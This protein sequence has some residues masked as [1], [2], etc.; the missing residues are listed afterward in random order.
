MAASFATYFVH[1][2]LLVP[3]II[4]HAV[5]SFLMFIPLVIS[6]TM[7]IDS[8]IYAEWKFRVRA[9]GIVFSCRTLTGNIG[10]ALASFLSGSILTL[11][12]YVANQEQ[13]LSSL[14]GLQSSLTIY[15][16]I[17]IGLSIIPLLFYALPQDSIDRMS[18]E[19]EMRASS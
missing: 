6:T 8:V 18:A 17:I 1:Y 13:S 3:L 7:F 4:L 10:I 11:I 14:Y 19:N 2:T 16:G 15:P 9:E 12:G 5:I